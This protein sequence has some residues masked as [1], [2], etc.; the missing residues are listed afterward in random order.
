[1]VARNLNWNDIRPI[2]NSLN[3]G[4]EELVCQ[5]AKLEKIEGAVRFIRNGKP[6]AGVECYWIL[7]NEVEIGWQAKFFINSF[8]AAQW[9][10]I[11]NSVKVTLEKHPKLKKYIIALPGKALCA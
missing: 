10:Q 2:N 1:M 4:F 8:D 9:R 3:E 11:D 7:D 5:L 6:D